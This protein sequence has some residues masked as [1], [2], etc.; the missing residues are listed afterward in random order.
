VR[1]S[2]YVAGVDQLP[3]LQGNTAIGGR[4][5]LDRALERVG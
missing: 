5:N 3:A 4:L 2:P 1:P